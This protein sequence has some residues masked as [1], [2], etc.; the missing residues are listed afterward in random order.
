MQYVS[1]LF[2]R[3]IA[4]SG[5]A[6]AMWATHTK[7][8]SELRNDVTSLATSFGCYGTSDRDLIECLRRVDWKR[9]RPTQICQVWDEQDPINAMNSKN[10][11]WIMHISDIIKVQPP[12]RPKWLRIKIP[13]VV[14]IQHC[15][16]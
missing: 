13:H 2:H 14:C 3:V 11:D 15:Y 6:N 12:S 4:Q 10:L 9:F 16:Q 5:T 7:P 1:G 8:M